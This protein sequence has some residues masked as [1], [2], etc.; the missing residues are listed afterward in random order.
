MKRIFFLLIV[1]VGL[2][3]VFNRSFHFP[4]MQ[5]SKTDGIAAITKQTEVISVDV[6]NVSTTI[7]PEDRPNLKAVY[8]GKQKLSVKENGDAIKVSVKGKW[9]HW[10]N[11]LSFSEKNKLIIYIPENY[12]QNMKIDLGSGNVNFSGES[13][14]NPMKLNELS[15]DIGSGNMKL[16]NLEVKQF[17]HDGASGN[18]N[19]NS[20]KAERSSF[21]L[22]S[23]NVDIQHYVG[24]I[25]A[26]VASGELDIQMDQLTD[27]IQLDLSSGNIKLDLPKSAD[28]TMK[29]DVSSGNISCNFPL[30]SKEINKGSINGR[31]GSGKHLIQLDVSSGNIHIF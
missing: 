28:F 26:D 8:N 14:T 19:V 11:W 23:G 12:D 31:H 18:V 5:A 13:R 29:G 1:I 22:G 3:L 30:K 24:A 16:K 9:F 10:F 21:D 6:A 25:K 20:L 17:E 27:S 15:I 4:V 2:Y 7:I